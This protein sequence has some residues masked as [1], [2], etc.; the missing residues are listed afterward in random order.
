TKPDFDAAKAQHDATRAQVEAA[1]A[2]L[3][4]IGARIA[5]AEAVVGTASLARE[6]TSLIAPFA[7]AV[8]QRNIEIGG[9]AGPGGPAV[10]L[11][12]LNSVKAAFGVPDLVAVTLKP[13]LSRPVSVEAFPDRHF[14]RTVTAIA[15]VADAN[16]RLF[17]VELTLPNPNRV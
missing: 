9:L 12:D 15:A 14:S 6:D 3:Q 17:Q 4:A 11:A 8:V 5:A 1:R 10:V 13:G 7:G 16:T 2:Q